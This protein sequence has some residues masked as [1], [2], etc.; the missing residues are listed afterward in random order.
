MTVRTRVL[1]SGRPAET[2]ETLELSDPTWQL[3]YDHFLHLCRNGGTNLDN[4]I[5][6]N[7]IFNQ[8]SRDLGL[9]TLNA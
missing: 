9:P 2:S 7:D 6:I 5:W 4:D 3:E 1:P 8:V